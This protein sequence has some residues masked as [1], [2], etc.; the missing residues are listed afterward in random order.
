MGGNFFVQNVAKYHRMNHIYTSEWIMGV[1]YTNRKGRTYHLCQGFTKT[2]KTRYYFAREITGEPVDEIPDGYK[3]SE[4]VNG[5]VS[6]VKDR[7]RLIHR[8]ELALVEDEIARHP[9]KRK[10][11]VHAKHDRIIIYEMSGPDV[12][13]L[14]R[15]LKQSGLLLPGAEGRVQEQLEQS[16]R[17]EALM[18]FILTDRDRGTYRAQRWCFLG[19]IDDWIDI[20]YGPLRELVQELI[21]RLGTEAFY[22]LY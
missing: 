21:P 20:D 13:R 7:P 6:L 14:T 3:I 15:I 8:K 11:R 2:G 22:D 9:E 19:G 17:Y 12:R 10:F 18:Q 1:T 5:I 16:G 4:S